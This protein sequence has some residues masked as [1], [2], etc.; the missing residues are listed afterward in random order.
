[1]F[2]FG[3]LYFQHNNLIK[4]HFDVCTTKVII[5]VTKAPI[6]HY[7]KKTTQRV[8]SIPSIIGWLTVYVLTAA[9]I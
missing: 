7:F 1:M 9:Y 2:T 8:F 6:T 4:I 3:V 5:S